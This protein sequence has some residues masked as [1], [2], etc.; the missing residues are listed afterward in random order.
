MGL[1]QSPSA[2]VAIEA[3][4]P[5]QVG[6]ATGVFHMGRFLSGSLGST[7]FGLVLQGDAGGVVGGFRFSVMLLVVMASLAVFAARRL[8]ARGQT[9]S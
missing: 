9:A 3:V 8:D 1:I 5:E 4:R 6:V 7:V 2:T